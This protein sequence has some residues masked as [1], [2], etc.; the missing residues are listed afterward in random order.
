MQRDDVKVTAL[1]ASVEINTPP[2]VGIYPGNFVPHYDF[3]FHPSLRL[4]DFFLSLQSKPQNLW[5]PL[6]GAHSMQVEST[7]QRPSD[8]KGFAR[9]SLICK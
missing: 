6:K 7:W 3:D 1:V 8:G 4:P 2:D 5:Y 9:N